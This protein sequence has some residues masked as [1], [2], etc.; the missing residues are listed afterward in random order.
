MAKM[1]HYCGKNGERL[2]PNYM[3][4]K[5]TLDQ[6]MLSIYNHFNTKAKTNKQKTTKSCYLESSAG[7]YL[8]CVSGHTPHPQDSSPSIQCSFVAILIEI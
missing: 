5:E 3:W 4:G 1:C 2:A 6:D 8:W 7:L